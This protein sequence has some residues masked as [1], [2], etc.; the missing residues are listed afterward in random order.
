MFQEISQRSIFTKQMLREVSSGNF[1][2]YLSIFDHLFIHSFIHSYIHQFVLSFIPLF[3]IYQIMC[4]FIDLLH[5][6]F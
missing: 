5:V 6:S 4:F 1:L 3:I 2:F